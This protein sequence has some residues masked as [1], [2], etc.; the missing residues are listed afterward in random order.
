ML[1]KRFLPLLLI[2]LLLLTA[3]SEPQTLED[4][5]SNVFQVGDEWAYL[6]RPG[7]PLSTFI[8]TKIDKA[9]IDG[10]EQ[11]IIHIAIT[12]LAIDHPDGGQVTAVPHMPFLE[13]ALFR[14]ANQPFDVIDPIPQEYLDAYGKWKE[15][16]EKGDASVFDSSIAHALDSLETSL[17][18][19]N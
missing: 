19:N 8:V 11:T 12:N 4:G 3:C 16:Y 6:T 2:M 17:Q 10:Q 9:T 7:E 14:S 5:T 15:R 1:K 13:Q 18:N